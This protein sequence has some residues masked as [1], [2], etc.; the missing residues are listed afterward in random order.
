[1]CR[2]GVRAVPY[3]GGGLILYI[4]YILYIL[5]ILFIIYILYILCTLYLLFT[6]YTYKSGTGGCAAGSG[7]EP[8][9]HRALVLLAERATQGDLLLVHGLIDE[10]VH[11]RLSKN[12][13]NSINNDNNN[14]N[15]NNDNSSN[16]R[17]NKA[18]IANKLQAHGAQRAERPGVCFRRSESIC[19]RIY[20]SIHLSIFLSIYLYVYPVYP[21][22]LRVNVHDLCS[23]VP[24]GAVM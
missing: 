18:I 22:V 24:R 17:S 20:P 5:F 23:A 6:Y 15:N 19:L 13:D 21:P 11:F 7:R 10:N 14:N 3:R 4:L 8:L 1:M 12:N 2:E 16:N 9:S